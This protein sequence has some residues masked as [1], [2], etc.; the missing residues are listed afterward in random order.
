MTPPIFEDGE[1][2]TAEQLN[3]LRDDMEGRMDD[4][5]QALVPTLLGMISAGAFRKGNAPD[6]DALTSH[7]AVGTHSY[8]S[9]ATGRPTSTG[10]SVIVLT[11]GG[12]ANSVQVAYTETDPVQ[13]WTRRRSGSSWSAWTPLSTLDTGWR[14]ITDLITEANRPET[15]PGE[16]FLKRTGN[17]VSL[18]LNDVVFSRD[19]WVSV[20][21]LPPGFRPAVE[22]PTGVFTGVSAGNIDTVRAF[23]VRTG[24]QLSVST[25]A[26]RLHRLAVTFD[27]SN[28]WPSTLPGT[29]A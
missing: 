16:I 15:Q 18:Q 12:G 7:D 28:A 17:S 10:G 21:T 22:V 13:V 19:A 1:I 8:T 5:L 6:L 3:A 14:D 24:G 9:S 26:G 11:T 27:T 4:Q 29:P 25:A 23:I 20:L 2:L